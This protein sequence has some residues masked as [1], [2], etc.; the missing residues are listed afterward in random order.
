[1]VGRPATP[2]VEAGTV[3]TPPPMGLPVIG[4]LPV[5]VV[6]G[7]VTGLATGTVTGLA[8]G[9]VAGLAAG[10]V[11]GFAAGA[12]AGLAAGTGGFT[13]GR[14]GKTGGLTGTCATAKFPIKSSDSNPII[15]AVEICFEFSLICM[16]FFLPFDP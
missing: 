1:M 7:T 8:A 12:G 5:T 2:L 11:A 15:A 16:A 10:G 14:G 6:G 4:G 3:E 9:G 13:A